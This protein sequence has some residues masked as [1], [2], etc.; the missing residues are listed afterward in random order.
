MRQSGVGRS[1]L[2]RIQN[3][4]GRL[5]TKEWKTNKSLRP[6]KTILAQCNTLSLGLS[7]YLDFFGCVWRCGGA[8]RRSTDWTSK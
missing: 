5:R 8:E 7:T 6:P 1:T 3:A 2:C 4:L